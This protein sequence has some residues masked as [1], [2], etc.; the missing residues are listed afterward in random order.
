MKYFCVLFFVLSALIVSSIVVLVLTILHSTK[1]SSDYLQISFADPEPKPNFRRLSHSGSSNNKGAKRVIFKKNVPIVRKR[2][3]DHRKNDDSYHDFPSYHDRYH[4]RD[5]IHS[6]NSND[7]GYK[8]YKGYKVD[9]RDKVDKGGYSSSGYKKP[10]HVTSWKYE[11]IGEKKKQ[12][13][14]NRNPSNQHDRD[15]NHA[16]ASHSTDNGCNGNNSACS[17]RCKQLH[18][19]PS[20]PNGDFKILLNI[21]QSNQIY[22][23]V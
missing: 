6:Y 5:H 3:L 23:S 20:Y 18:V 1:I 22:L 11:I 15:H 8:G 12:H 14:E 4:D 10:G 21:S 19:T 13:Q 16:Y 17:C 9:K 2:Q 7:K